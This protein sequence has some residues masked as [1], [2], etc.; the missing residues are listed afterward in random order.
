M[1][2]GKSV[3]MAGVHMRGDLHLIEKPPAEGEK[4]RA[5]RTA[6]S[7][8]KYV[9]AVPLRSATRRLRHAQSQHNIYQLH[10]ATSYAITSRRDDILPHAHRRQRLHWS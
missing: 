8:G 2:G 10:L 7:I 4:P 6:I 9:S 3:V 5:P 1:L